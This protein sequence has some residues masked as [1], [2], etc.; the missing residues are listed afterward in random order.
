MPYVIEKQDD[1]FCVVK[2]DN[3]EVIGCHD[4]KEEAH[5]QMQALHANEKCVFL[6]EFTDDYFKFSGYGV[7]FNTEDLQGEIFTK[8]TD[9]MLESIGK[10]PVLFNHNMREIKGV[11]GHAIVSAVDDLGILFD[12]I[13]KRSN[14]YASL[15]QKLVNMGRLGLSTGALPQTAEKEGSVIKIW[16]IGEISLTETP[17][18]FRTLNLE[19]VKLLQ[20]LNLIP[21]QEF[22]ESENESV[23]ESE[24]LNNLSLEEVENEKIDKNEKVVI[25][26]IGEEF[27]MEN[28]ITNSDVSAVEKKIELMEAA[29]NR[30]LGF[31]E[32]TPAAKA[33]YITQDG[34]TADFT[35][36]SFGDFLVAIKRNDV[37]RLMKVYGSIKDLSESSGAAGGYLVPSEYGNELISV[38]AMINEVY[39]RVQKVPVMRESGTYP[40]LDQYFAPTAGAGNTAFAGGVAP[41]FTAAGQE[42]TET[43]PAFEML[44]WRLNKIGGVTE[45]ENELIE[46]SPFAIEA[47]LRGL[48]QVAIAARNE[49]NILRGSGVGEPLGILNASAA[50]GVGDNTT[51]HFK[52]EDV[53]AMYA[54]FKGTSGRPVWIIH[55]SVWAD[56]MVMNNSSVTAWQTSLSGAP[57][58]FLN[59]YP[60]ITSE[61]M[62]Q[63]GA[64]GS[65]LLADLSAY[66]MFEK[67]GLAIA[68]SEHVNFKTDKGTWRFRQRNDGKPWLQNPITLAG[69]GS[70][71]TVSPFVY[72]VAG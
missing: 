20:E 2:Q 48:F 10:I 66:V 54:K 6:K 59:G 70:A 46:D 58:N 61:H 45:V 9:F 44:Q 41:S 37:N 33:G 19:E 72:N 8:D 28:E 51:G 55:P 16:Q 43:Q 27:K 15:V 4:T 49:R 17:A 67:A 65:V 1:R 57:G 47:L 3:R 21:E 52:W 63:L 5:S 69:P 7:V 42:F 14:K 12:I 53:G 38:A 32:N 30:I 25:S 50:V 31:V 56:I 40:A 18:E 36:K 24:E 34:G 71:Y 26:V 39:S 35:N 23:I 68:Y 29:I 13:I 62:P 22:S 60:V 64:T 11:L